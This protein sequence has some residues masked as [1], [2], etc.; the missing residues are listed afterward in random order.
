MVKRI[1]P[2]TVVMI[3]SVGQYVSLMQKIGMSLASQNFIKMDCQT[4]ISYVNVPNRAFRK[5]QANIALL[6]N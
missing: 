6:H 5:S 3:A 1:N 2:L 4:I